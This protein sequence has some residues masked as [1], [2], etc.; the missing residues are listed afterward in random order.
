[1]C[2]HMEEIDIPLLVMHLVIIILIPDKKIEH[3]TDS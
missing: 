2:E 1:M 3:G